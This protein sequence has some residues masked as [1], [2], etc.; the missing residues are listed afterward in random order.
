MNQLYASAVGTTV[1][2]VTEIYRRPPDYDGWLCLFGVADEV[3]EVA[4]RAVLEMYGMIVAVVDRRVP[5]IERAGEMSVQFASHA[6]ALKVMTALETRPMTD[7]WK[8]VGTLYN[9]RPYNDRGW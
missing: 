3:N 2:Q 5:P 9:D 7:L 6:I 1:L 8:G 4:V